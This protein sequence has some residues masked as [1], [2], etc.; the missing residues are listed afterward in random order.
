MAAILA[1]IFSAASFLLVVDGTPAS[2]A[3]RARLAPDRDL[4]LTSEERSLLAKGK[5]VLREIPSPGRSGRTYE[6]VGLIQSSL[7]EAVSV[8]TDFER[9]PEF[10]PNVSAVRLCERVHPCSVIETT[11]RLPLGIKKRYRLR[12]TV[13]AQSAEAFELVWEKLPW[14]ELKPSQTVADTSG[15]W[16]V[17]G[18]EEGGLIVVYHVYTDAGRVPL[19][20]SGIARA[21]AKDKIPDGIVSLR[22]RIRSVFHPSAR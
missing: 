20:L 16:L 22:E 5:I 13:A 18:F 7:N 12:Y 14:P 17:R 8:L 6:A 15:Y 3:A 19:G 1:M 11:L 10:M 4:S 2:A 9:Y 21:L